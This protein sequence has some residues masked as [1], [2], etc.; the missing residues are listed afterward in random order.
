MNP[1]ALDREFGLHDSYARHRP[2]RLQASRLD[3]RNR[4]CKGPMGAGGETYS[5]RNFCFANGAK[6]CAQRRL[7]SFVASARGSQR[8]I[9]ITS[10][11][12]KSS[13]HCPLTFNPLPPSGA[14]RR[15]R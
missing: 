8:I 11:V 15:K 6:E 5:L 13:N 3:S 10:A 2:T 7:P 1:I 4:V 14:R 9:V 12:S